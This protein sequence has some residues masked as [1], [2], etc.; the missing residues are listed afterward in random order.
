MNKREAEF[1]ISRE[2]N[3]KKV[4]GSGDEVGRGDPFRNLEFLGD[5]PFP[6]Q[7]CTQQHPNKLQTKN[8]IMK[9]TAILLTALTTAVVAKAQ[10]AKSSYSVTTDF[11]YASDYVFRGV[12]IA[13]D[14]FQPS[15]EISVRDFYV[16]LWTNQPI[17]RHEDNEL[18]FYAGY[19]YKVTEKLSV[20]AVGTYYWYPEAGG[21]N[22]RHSNEVGIGG[23]Y[24][25]RGIS[26]SVYYYRDLRLD[27][28]TIQGSLG[29]SLP[30]EAIGAS[31]DLS[32]YG[33]NV[34]GSDL[35]PDAGIK[36]QESYSYYGVDV[37]VPYKLSEKS[38][39][40]IGG[41][42]AHNRNLPGVD[43]DYVWFSA[44]LTVGF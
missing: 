32:I 22:T 39:F 10:D 40:T 1:V 36:V 9:K 11:A 27:A 15:V 41:H 28:D 8:Y 23:T 4:S 18:D 42:W 20:E 38:T 37:S 5:P 19:K 21:G 16:G 43:D 29:Y 2:R 13:D 14:S 33:G 35:L 12:K 7:C 44:G 30:L 31:L 25:L 26:A 17:K 24:S 3:A 34:D 6:S